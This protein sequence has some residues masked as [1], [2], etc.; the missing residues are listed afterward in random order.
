MA[1][2][3]QLSQ[4]HNHSSCFGSQVAW[5]VSSKWAL[6][7][8]GALCCGKTINDFIWCWYNN[9]Y[10]TIVQ[11]CPLTTIPLWGSYDT[12]NLT[13]ISL[14]STFPFISRLFFGT[15]I[16][17]AVWLPQ[18]I[19]PT[20]HHTRLKFS[21]YTTQTTRINISSTL[22]NWVPARPLS[23]NLLDH[24]YGRVPKTETRGQARPWFRPFTIY[25]VILGGRTI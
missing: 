13:L 2:N 12:K 7:H 18:H 23:T 25:E 11:S 9:N 4:C 15:V 14:L 20:T 1:E 24:Q 17:G 22:T 5:R 16:L 21:A 3:Q 8:C 19:V 6:A 10:L